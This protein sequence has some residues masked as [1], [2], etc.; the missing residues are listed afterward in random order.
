MLTEAAWERRVVTL[1]HRHGWTVGRFAS[2]K[3]DPGLPD[4]LLVHPAGDVLGLELKLA[5]GDIRRS[6]RE[7]IDAM[8]AGGTDAVIVRPQDAGWLDLRLGRHPDAMLDA[9][10]LK[11]Q[12]TQSRTGPIADRA[13]L[14]AVGD[15]FGVTVADLRDRVQEERVVFARQVFMDLAHRMGASYP[16]AAAA[17]RR[18]HTTAI[19]ARRSV[20][21][22][23]RWD[24]SARHSVGLICASTLGVSAHSLY[25]D[26]VPNEWEIAGL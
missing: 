25:G 13:L 17:V 19:Q 18:H 6:Q 7:T 8:Q 26:D 3:S 11:P 5:H 9:P 22:R 14:E 15:A 23:L 21:A 24:A 10:R 12:P 4:L 2:V 20:L 1:A 16:V